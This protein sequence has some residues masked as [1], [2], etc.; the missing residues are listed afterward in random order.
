MI[1]FWV[2]AD[3]PDSGDAFHYLNRPVAPNLGSW[4]QDSVGAERL[5][6]CP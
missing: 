6:V 5:F 4:G 1:V 2:D 3:V